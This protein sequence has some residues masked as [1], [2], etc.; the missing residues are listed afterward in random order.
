[1]KVLLLMTLLYLSLCAKQCNEEKNPSGTNDCKDLEVDEGNHCCYTYI[2]M[3][4]EGKT[5]ENKY[6][7][8]I[9]QEEYD[10]IKD[11]IDEGK[12]ILKKNFSGA[13]IKKFSLD[14]HSNYLNIAFLSLFFI[15]F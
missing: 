12:E 1:M 15:L 3:K 10:N 9:T 6:C 5:G 4:Y 13:S 2:K 14:C 7:A 8:E 11:I